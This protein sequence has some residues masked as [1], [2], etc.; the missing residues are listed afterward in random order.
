MKKISAPSF[1]RAAAILAVLALMGTLA[2]GVVAADI[3][4]YY[5]LQVGNSWSYTTEKHTKITQGFEIQET[6]KRGTIEQRVIGPSR[7][8]TKELKV[9]EVRHAVEERGS[10]AASG[11]TTETV[12]HVSSS[13]SAIDL[14]AVDF[15]GSSA[16]KLP[17]PVAILHVPPPTQPETSESAGLQTTRT[18]KSQTVEAVKVPAGRFPKAIKRVT[19]GVVSGSLS[20]LPVRSGTITETSWFVR[21]VGL[22]R[23]DRLLDITLGNPDASQVRVQEQDKMVLQKFSAAKAK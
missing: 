22:V 16:S 10:D 18:V 15:E 4:S 12:L 6:D 17:A 13:P 2:S 23:Q 1:F 8:S 19:Q 7:F 14:Q 3:R 21:N 9:F 5:P 11:L 20:V